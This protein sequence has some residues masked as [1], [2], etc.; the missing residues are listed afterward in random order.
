MCGGAH[1]SPWSLDNLLD[2]LLHQD[3]KNEEEDIKHL[4][5]LVFKDEYTAY[6]D[7]LLQQIFL[8]A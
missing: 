4:A 2:N 3:F 1:S 5:L 7:L 8:L 6:P